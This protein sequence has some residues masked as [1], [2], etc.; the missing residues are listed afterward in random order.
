MSASLAATTPAETPE[1]KVERSVLETRGSL[2]AF[3]GIDLG[4]SSVK[5]VAVSTSGKILGLG[6][7]EYPILTPQPGWAEQDPEQWWNATT[8]AV[9]QA[10]NAAGQPEIL[11]IGFS[12]QMHGPVLLDKA[13]KLL[14]NAIIWA[15][16]RGAS[17]LSEIEERVER[18]ILATV[19]GTAPAAGFLI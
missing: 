9:R 11:A 2:S 1:L 13:G 19:C 12:G 15:D 4:T 7:V 5:V 8:R 10:I 6:S 16:Q 18:R 3:L 17:V 14:G